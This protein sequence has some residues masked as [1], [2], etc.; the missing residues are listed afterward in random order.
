[1]AQCP[2]MSSPRPDA[3]ALLRARRHTLPDVI[4]PGLRVLF[5]GIN[6][7]LYSTAVGHH[8]GRPGNRF[9]KVLHASGFTPR[10]FSPSEDKALLGF[11]VGITN[12]CPRTTASADELTTAELERGGRELV[13]KA[14]RF[15]PRV[16]AILGI[17]AYRAGFG[18]LDA[19]IGRQEEPIAQALTWVLPNPSGLNAHYGLEALTRHF[20]MLR[21]AVESESARRR[22]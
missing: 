2:E 18:R 21:V 14:R 19:V 20:R 11:G 7:G 5:C 10:L 16:V 8:F 15:R 9:W 17:G 6:P 4:A 12:L 1:M 22:R 13:A 3:A